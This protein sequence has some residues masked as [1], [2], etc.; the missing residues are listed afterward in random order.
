MK[1]FMLLAM[2]AALLFGC[3]TGKEAS[4]MEVL[5]D[6]DKQAQPKPVEKK[7][8]E[9]EQAKEEAKPIVEE[10]KEQVPPPEKLKNQ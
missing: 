10:A 1:R 3:Q 2:L 4:V 9:A 7:A 8:A 6:L 5:D